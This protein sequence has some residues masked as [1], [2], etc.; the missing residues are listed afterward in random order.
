MLGVVEVLAE[1]VEG[2]LVL[3]VAASWRSCVNGNSN[4][5]SSRVN[6]SS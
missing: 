2:V 3:L 5:I 4:S 1:V 6:G